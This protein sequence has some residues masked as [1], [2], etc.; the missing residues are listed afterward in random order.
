MTF[1]YA[2]RT[3]PLSYFFIT[4]PRKLNVTYVFFLKTKGKLAG[5]IVPN[6]VCL[7][8]SPKQ[9]SP[10]VTLKNFQNLQKSRGLSR[11]ALFSC[12]LNEAF[13]SNSRSKQTNVVMAVAKRR[14]TSNIWLVKWNLKL[15]GSIRSKITTNRDF[16]A[17]VCPCFASPTRIFFDIWL[18]HLTVSSCC[19]W[20]QIL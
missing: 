15:N 3:L 17:H 4:L 9:T 7:C 6:G 10:V 16:F 18:V 13:S 1:F 2:S 12:G 14:Q 11:T 8:L 20:P 19:D 5:K